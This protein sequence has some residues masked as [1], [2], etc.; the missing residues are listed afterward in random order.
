MYK[1][2]TQVFFLQNKHVIF[3]HFLKLA[4]WHFGC[5]SSSKYVILIRK[6]VNLKLE[7]MKNYDKKK[8]PSHM[9]S[10]CN[11]ASHK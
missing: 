11:K 9:Q 5:I 6:H 7:W 3:I 1:I 2:K 4:S 10:A 8:N